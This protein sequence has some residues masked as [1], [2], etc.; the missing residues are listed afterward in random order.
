[1][2][3]ESHTCHKLHVED[4]EAY[5]RKPRRKRKLVKSVLKSNNTIPGVLAILLIISIFQAIQLGSLKKVASAQE[6]P[7]VKSVQT[8]TTG[9]ST[10]TAPAASSG[11]SSLPTQ[12]GGC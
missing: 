12:V 11:T 8:K 9:Q 4:A 5:H 10:Q 2:E 3:N 7:T 1:M 6:T